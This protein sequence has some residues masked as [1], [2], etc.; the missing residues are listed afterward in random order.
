MSPDADVQ[1]TVT[2]SDNSTF[3]LLKESSEVSAHLMSDESKIIIITTATSS[4]SLLILY[5]HQI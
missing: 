1:L 4:H 2:E 5:V 3:H